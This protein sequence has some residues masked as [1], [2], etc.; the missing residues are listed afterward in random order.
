MR[1]IAVIGRS[2]PARART[3][4]WAITDA[5]ADWQLYAVDTI[6]VD[7]EGRDENGVRVLGVYR[8]MYT[9]IS[10]SRHQR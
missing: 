8:G 6:M 4:V 5:G 9:T 1:L 7:P 3:Y 2:G 10:G